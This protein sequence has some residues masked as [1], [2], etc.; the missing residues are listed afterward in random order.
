MKKVILLTVICFSVLTGTAMAQ[1]I[2]PLNVFPWTLSTE[3]VPLYPENIEQ[4]CTTDIIDSLCEVNTEGGTLVV[5]DIPYNGTVEYSGSVSGEVPYAGEAPYSGTVEY[6]GSQ[7]YSGTLPIE[8]S[9]TVPFN[10]YEKS[11]IGTFTFAS[12]A[13]LCTPGVDKG[14]CRAVGDPVDG[15]VTVV[16]QKID[17]E[18]IIENGS[19]QYDLCEEKTVDVPWTY[20]GIGNYDGDVPYN[21]TASYSGTAPFS[22]AVAYNAPFSGSV[23]YSGT[24]QTEVKEFAATD[25]LYNEGNVVMD[26]PDGGDV[27]T[28][29][30]TFRELVTNA[31]VGDHIEI[32][33]TGWTAV[34]KTVASRIIVKYAKPG[35][36]RFTLVTRTDKIQTVANGIF[37]TSLDGGLTFD[38]AGTYQV[39]FKVWKPNGTVAG[40]T[41]TRMITVVEPPV[42]Q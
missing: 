23:A 9:G 15:S 31:Y 7:H 12:T 34:E 11:G 14:C 38:K 4:L 39:V 13:P 41:K 30:V 6:S 5:K 21:G 24:A 2:Q 36:T 16:C 18:M 10:T 8:A 19:F 27:A 22:G 35:K 26:C 20:K 28:Q 37:K 40:A 1:K 32:E 25:V 29:D 17:P 42:A 33:A 3:A